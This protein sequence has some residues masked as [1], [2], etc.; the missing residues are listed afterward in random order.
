MIL[1]WMKLF[2]L[3]NISLV[4]KKVLFEKMS[5]KKQERMEGR[6]KDDPFSSYLYLL[7]YLS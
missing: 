6:K 4:Q 1:S 3:Y 5:I 7:F 2:Y